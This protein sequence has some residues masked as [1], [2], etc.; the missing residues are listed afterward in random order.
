MDP[1]QL[2]AA[3]IRDSVCKPVRQ[4]E[5]L[6]RLALLMAPGAVT[7][8]PLPVRPP[9]P[10]PPP[11][12]G[13]VL[14]VEDNEINQMVAL[15]LLARLGFQADVAG[16][17]QEALE[18]LASQRYHAVLMDCRMPRMDGYTAT[19]L[20]RDR[21]WEGAAPHLPVIA[22]T[23]SALAEDRERCLAAGM[24][25]YLTKPL[26]ASDLER[27]LRRWIGEE[28]TGTWAG[29]PPTE[30]HP[31]LRRLAELRGDDTEESLRLVTGLAA[32][33]L[34]R[35]P[36]LV[37][38]LRAAAERGDATSIE[39]H[40]HTLKGAAGNIGAADLA[41]C[42]AELEDLARAGRGAEAPRVAAGLGPLLDEV[43][44]T[45]LAAGLGRLPGP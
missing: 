1:A 43:R 31:V 25:D 15:G 10:A 16:D 42:A 30:A 19:H 21:E 22:M 14:L 4:A 20:L 6:E 2:Q 29:V 17:G 40:A 28:P 5:L 41:S 13:K 34:E 32:S 8:T 9:T 18:L 39:E 11:G 44:R 23:A 36:G 26:A 33:F 27:A 35:A 37:D 38:A 12:R 45:L 3:G 24:D 7:R